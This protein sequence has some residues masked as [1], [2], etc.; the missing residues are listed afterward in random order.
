[1]EPAR[2][3]GGGRDCSGD[4]RAEVGR[5]ARQ[6]RHSRNRDDRAGVEREELRL[7]VCGIGLSKLMPMTIRMVV[8]ESLVV[9]G[10]NL[11]TVCRRMSEFDCQFRINADEWLGCMRDRAQTEGQGQNH[12][13]SQGEDT[14]HCA[15]ISTAFPDG[16]VNGAIAKSDQPS[17]WRMQEIWRPSANVS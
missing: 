9:I 15:R 2:N 11:V 17:D 4:W 16:E 12:R 7:G 10:G 13:K 5:A 8:R 1:M 14:T 3:L 6:Y